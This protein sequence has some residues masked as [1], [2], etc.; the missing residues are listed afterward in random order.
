MASIVSHLYC[1]TQ[2]MATIATYEGLICFI[3][4]SIL[5]ICGLNW[6]QLNQAKSEA[7]DE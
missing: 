6:N 4:F 7:K 2:V 3:G 1:Y 5:N